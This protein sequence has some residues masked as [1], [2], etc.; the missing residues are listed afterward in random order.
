M[1]TL[2]IFVGLALLSCG[3]K[4]TEDKKQPQAPKIIV[5]SSQTAAPP[6][7]EGPRTDYLVV[8]E[9][10][11]ET[12]QA[13]YKTIWLKAT[14][15]GYEEIGSHDGVA[16]SDGKSVWFWS[17]KPFLQDNADCDCVNPLYEKGDPS[18][19]D[20]K[21]CIHKKTLP[22]AAFYDTS[23]KELPIKSWHSTTAPASSE[24]SSTSAP[25]SGPS[26]DDVA[27]V[28]SSLEFMSTLGPYV[29]YAESSYYF[30]CGAAHGGGGV[31]Y[32]VVDLRRALSDL[33]WTNAE[34]E[35]Y[36][37]PHVEK[38]KGVLCTP[39]FAG[40]TVDGCGMTPFSYEVTALFP[41]FIG[42]QL[43]TIVQYTVPTNYAA[44]DGF[45]GSYLRSSRI[46]VDVPPAFLKDFAEV[47]ATV[48]AY[49]SQN[50]P[51]EHTGWS[52]VTGAAKEVE[53]LRDS[54][55]KAPLMK[56]KIQSAE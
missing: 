7:D 3:V 16:A 15:S 31:S 30:P 25:S 46:P 53:A 44:S 11:V 56:L 21:K 19:A 1:R 40:D 10:K 39:D 50:P 28:S 27:E 34:Q 49:W 47:P 2:S 48:K 14:P 9:Q 18:D 24:P 20:V 32:S 37:K 55:M 45:S 29:F 43:K 52:S 33:P 23:N 5:A 8:V 38:A 36:T 35:A 4:K 42:G 51:G 26:I 41:T 12:G 13:S 22:E 54:F 6:K 17:D